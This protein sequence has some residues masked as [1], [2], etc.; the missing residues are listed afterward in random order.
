MH[1]TVV[2]VNSSKLLIDDWR[3]TR[4]LRL[5]FGTRHSARDGPSSISPPD[6]VEVDGMVV[7]DEALD[8]T[9]AAQ[10]RPPTNAMVPRAILSDAVFLFMCRRLNLD[11]IQIYARPLLADYTNSRK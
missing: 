11:F 4:P 5:T 1:D 8:G 3:A 10:D 6:V 7:V 9:D 2:R